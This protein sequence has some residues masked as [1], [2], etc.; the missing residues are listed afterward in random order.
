MCNFVVV[1]RSFVFLCVNICMCTF[2]SASHHLKC[3]CA[4]YSCS[5]HLQHLCIYLRIYVCVHKKKQIIPHICLDSQD[6]YAPLTWVSYHGHLDMVKLLTDKGAVVNVKNYEGNTA[7]MIASQRN[8]LNIV[9]YLIEKGA[10]INLRN[11]V[12]AAFT[13]LSGSLI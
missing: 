6:G 4:S 2:I 7:L 10:E 8:H 9:K 1:Y 5:Y 13:T 11:A 12:S 3:G